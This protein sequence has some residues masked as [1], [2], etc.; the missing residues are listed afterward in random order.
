MRYRM[1]VDNLVDK[2]ASYPHFLIRL[3]DILVDNFLL[4]VGIFNISLI[5]WWISA[6][7]IG[8]APCFEGAA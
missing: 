5:G 1:M 3:V 6:I 7:E 4:C 8:H 2:W